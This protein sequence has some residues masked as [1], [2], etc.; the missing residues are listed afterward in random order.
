MYTVST[1]LYCPHN[2]IKNTRWDGR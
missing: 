1:P 2:K